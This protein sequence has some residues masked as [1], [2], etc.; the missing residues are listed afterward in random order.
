M[1]AYFGL[2][3]VGQPKPGETVVVSAASGAVGQVV[4]QLAKIAGCR[5]VGIAGGAKKCAFVKDTLGFDACI[6][7]KAEKDLDRRRQGR[8]PQRRR[9]LLR[10]RRRHRERRGARQ[11]Q[12]LC[13]RG[14]VRLDLAIQ[15]RPSRARA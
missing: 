15:H 8:L 2:F 10:Q 12:L 3:E 14:A 4:G 1:T 6:D 5:V 9:R 7:Y 11:P 13:P